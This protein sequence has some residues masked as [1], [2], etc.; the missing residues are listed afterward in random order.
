MEGVFMINKRG[1]EMFFRLK[2]KRGVSDTFK[3]PFNRKIKNDR[4]NN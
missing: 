2:S 3:V 1:V 4:K